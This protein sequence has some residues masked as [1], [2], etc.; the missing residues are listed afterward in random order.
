METS[1]TVTSVVGNARA[2]L[3]FGYDHKGRRTSKV[4][5]NWTGSAWTLSKNLKYNY[6][7]WNLVGELDATDTLIPAAT[8]GDSASVAS[9]KELCQSSSAIWFWDG[10]S[11]FG[12]LLLSPFEG[13]GKIISLRRPSLVLPSVVLSEIPCSGS[14]RLPAIVRV[15]PLPTLAPAV[16]NSP[17]SERSG[18][19]ASA[20]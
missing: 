4:V 7:G 3:L 10:S 11:P 9:S 14:E 18:S 17:H 13:E 16:D 2:K 20:S 5:S 19:L 1:S 15:A 8:P 6:D 12:V